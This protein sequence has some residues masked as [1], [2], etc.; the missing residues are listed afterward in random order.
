MKKKSF[1]KSAIKS[2]GIIF[3]VLC[4]LVVSLVLLMT[5]NFN[6]SYENYNTTNSDI[7]DY[8]K[9]L[10][11]AHR[12]GGGIFP[13]NTMMAFEGCINSDTFKTDIF[14]FDLHITKDN[15]LII[16]HD[17]TLD[18]T[19]DAEEVF[20]SEDIRPENY[21]Y[22]EL[23]VLNFGENFENDRGE[24]PYKGL[25]GDKVPTNLRA[26]KLSDVL[27]YLQSHGDFGYII[28]I[29]N[30]G[31]FGNKAADI[32]YSTLKERDLLD[33][34]VIGTFNGGVTRYM[35]EN[36][37]DMKRSASIKE[38]VQ[39]YFLSLLGMDR[40]GAYKFDA[41]QIPSGLS[42]LRLD[43]VRLI[44]YAHRHDI[45]VQYWTINDE[46]Q[47]AHLRDIGA[48]CIMSD[49]PDIAYNVLNAQ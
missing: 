32:L 11:S 15:Q 34:A 37:P 6:D 48:D 18:R 41:L 42:I 13:E 3:G 36:Y 12:S 45:A 4:V 46:A 19:T 1:L 24:M 5:H 44:N 27:D 26:A 7:T 30:S 43:T 10:V 9:T 21:T 16:L 49:I 14:E 29:K 31:E 22:E 38:V 47:M 28:E 23:S 2:A 39:V 20:G 8:G 33:N 17:N 35:D 25:R 40:Q